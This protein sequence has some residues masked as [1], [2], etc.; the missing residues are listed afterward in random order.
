MTEKQKNIVC[1]LRGLIAELETL[2]E[3]YNYNYEHESEYD[4]ESDEENNIPEP[5]DEEYLKLRYSMRFCKAVI[6]NHLLYLGIGNTAPSARVSVDHELFVLNTLF[7]END[8]ASNKICSI[9][10]F[11]D[12]VDCS[13][14][15]SIIMDS[16]GGITFYGHESNIT[17]ENS[18]DTDDDG[19]IHDH[20]DTD[21]YDYE[22]I[23]EDEDED[24]D[25]G[26]D[27]DDENWKRPSGIK[28]GNVDELFDDFSNHDTR[29][30][31]DE[32]TIIAEK[33]L[34]V[35]EEVTKSA[36]KKIVR[37]EIRKAF[38]D[39]RPLLKKDVRKV[40][41]KYYNKTEDSIIGILNEL[42]DMDQKL[43]GAESKNI[44][45][46]PRPYP[47]VNRVMNSDLSSKT[48]KIE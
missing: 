22:I 31:T 26:D 40:V 13:G 14:A 42:Q 12:T 36:I 7:A 16:D 19:I 46:I 28:L 35:L 47:F 17:D 6:I 37:K 23:D 32:V 1:G 15:S 4:C 21:D 2:K 39:H 33:V 9:K 5:S 27:E 10:E 29:N 43:T 38:D 11:T 24:D 20:G 3:I 18:D 48:D 45:P 8:T 34:E 44:L 41:K 30:S 25:D